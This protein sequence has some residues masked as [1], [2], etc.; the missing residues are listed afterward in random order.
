MYSFSRVSYSKNN[1]NFASLGPESWILELMIRFGTCGF[2]L[3]HGGWVWDLKVGF[4]NRRL[5]LE[6]EGLYWDLNAGLGLEG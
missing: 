5:G 2:G 3:G 4:L 6:L 1:F